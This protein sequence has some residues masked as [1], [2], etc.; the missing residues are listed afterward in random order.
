VFASLSAAGIPAWMVNA[1][2]VKQVPGRKT[3][4]ADSDDGSST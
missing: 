4:V 3:E 2:H 1:H